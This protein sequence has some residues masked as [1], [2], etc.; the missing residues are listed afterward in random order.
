M[1]AVPAGE[2]PTCTIDTI[3]EQDGH[4]RPNYLVQPTDQLKKKERGTMAYQ[5]DIHSWAIV[6]R[7]HDSI[8][9]MVVSNCNEVPGSYFRQF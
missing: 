9:V 1:L 3:F 2:T 7:W 5:H 8:V 6:N 4:V